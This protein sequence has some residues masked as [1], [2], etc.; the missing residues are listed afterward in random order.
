MTTLL[1]GLLLF[2]INLVALG[3]VPERR[4][5]SSAMAWLLLIFFLPG[6]GLLLFLLIGSPYVPSKRREEQR[7]AGEVIRA[8]LAGVPVLPASPDRPDWLD[9]VM[10]LNRHLAWMPA[11]QN[12][13]AELFAGYEESIQAKADLIRTAERYVHVEYFMICRDTTSE[14]FIAAL[15]EVAA[16]GVKVRVL[17]D[18]L[19]TIGLPGHKELLATFDRA[20]IEWHPMLPIQPLK[21][22]WR[23]PDL[24]NHRKIVV[25]DGR[26][27]FVGSQNIIDASYHKKK[28]EANGRKW[29]ELTARVEGPVVQSLSLVFASDWYIET[30]ERLRDYVQTEEFPADQG[31]L[32]CQIVP[33]GPGFPDENNLRLFNAL[34]YG[35]Q[36]RLSIASP[37]FVPDESLLYAITTAAQRGVAVELF[38]SEKGEQLMVS[39]AQCSYY[40]YLLEAGVRI[41]MYPY[42]FVLHSKHFSVD[43]HTAVIGSSNMDIRSFNLDFEVSMMCTGASFVA[44]MREVEDSYRSVCRELTLAEWKKRPLTQRWLDNVMRLT[45]AVQ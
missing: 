19:S 22:Q 33:S 17:F 13:S 3:L 38:V 27:G 44:K 25:V 23:R 29:R 40:R 31:D 41:F 21:R 42:P 6:V 9:P 30:H 4:R 39:H 15:L 10:V 1:I 18:H 43:D 20:G 26:T 14:P 11:V 2:L 16:R 5:P 28:H 37:Y 45:S 8:G 36:E 35:A 32:T 34:I 7:V 12:N 24:R